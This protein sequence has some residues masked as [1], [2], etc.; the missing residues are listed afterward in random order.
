M[1][2]DGFYLDLWLPYFTSLAFTP[3]EV[4]VDSFAESR[5]RDVL[6]LAEELEH[7]DLNDTKCSGPQQIS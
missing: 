2:P 1:M 6:H 3:A 4:I 5:Q 7:E